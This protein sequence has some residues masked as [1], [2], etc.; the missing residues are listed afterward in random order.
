MENGRYTNTLTEIS[1][2]IIHI[3]E[4]GVP[5]GL[6]RK[7]IAEGFQLANG[8]VVI[9]TERDENGYYIGGTGID[10]M[11]LRTNERYEPCFDCDNFINAFR[12][13]N[14]WVITFT[15]D[16]QALIAQYALNTKT[17]LMDDLQEI[18]KIRV[19]ASFHTLVQS[20]LEKLTLIPDE[21]CRR[22]M[23]DIY[24]VYRQ[25]NLRSLMHDDV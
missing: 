12:L 20:T 7:H 3:K 17:N 13:M 16:E 4:I 24:A 5:M 19:P 25:R 10:G 11:F 15:P 21:E 9:E 1:G 23:A 6:G 14:Q 2:T 18:L 22:L 8:S